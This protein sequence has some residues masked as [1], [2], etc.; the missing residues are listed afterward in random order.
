MTT[1][2]TD[3][4]RLIPNTEEYLNNLFEELG[5]KEPTSTTA[6]PTATPTTSIKAEHDQPEK[7]KA[8]QTTHIIYSSSTS[9]TP[10]YGSEE[11]GYTHTVKQETN[12]RP[13]ENIQLGHGWNKDK[14]PT[15]DDSSA[16]FDSVYEQ[17]KHELSDVINSSD[18]IG[19]DSFLE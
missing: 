6:T 3:M 19:L 10:T 14:K 17:L 2:L 16:V 7:T 8:T 5:L 18:E 15:A 11:A 1:I 13:I 12:H 9:Y 4:Q